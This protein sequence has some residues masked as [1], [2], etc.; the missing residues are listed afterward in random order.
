MMKDEEL[1]E[2]IEEVWEAHRL[3]ATK[4]GFP[5]ADVDLSNPEFRSELPKI[6]RS[7][8]ES[9]VQDNVDRSQWSRLTQVFDDLSTFD[10]VSF[11]VYL[12][13]EKEK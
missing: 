13:L 10:V 8:I 6:M 7:L 11:M 9:H 4:A 1:R 2:A 5:L 3:A 12:S